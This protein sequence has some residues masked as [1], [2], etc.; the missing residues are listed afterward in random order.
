MKT[1]RKINEI[2]IHCTDTE[3]C[4]PVTLD[5]LRRWHVDER[6]FSGIGYHYFIDHR[7]V[8]HR[9]RPLE[10]AGAHCKGYNRHSI[11]ICYAGGR[12]DG[13]YRDTRSIIQKETLYKLIEDLC[14]SFPITKITGHNEYSNKVCPC[15]D[16]KK[17]YSHLIKSIL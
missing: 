16:A 5:D 12:L 14:N 8:L 15:F 1:K 7:G 17:E 6:G 3:F 2:I 13:N 4:D 9:C 10:L 11:G